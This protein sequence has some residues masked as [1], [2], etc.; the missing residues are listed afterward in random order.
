M[1]NSMNDEHKTKE[2]LIKE[3]EKKFGGF[4]Y[5]L[6]MGSKDNVIISAIEK[7]LKMNEE[8]S[9]DDNNKDY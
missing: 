7:A 1:N 5:F 9:V 6:F 4:P 3:Y 8:I 2:Q